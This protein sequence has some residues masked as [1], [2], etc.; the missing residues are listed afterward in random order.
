MSLYDHTKIEKKWQ[1]R[2]QKSNIYSSK[3]KSKKKK[4]YILDMFPYPSGDGLH[5]GHVKGYT[6]SDVL[7]R[8]KRMRGFNVLHPMGWDAFGLPAE[9]FAI[10]TRVH[11]KI[12]TERAIENFKKQIDS[13]GLSYDWGR[14][15]DTH[16]KEYYRWT[17]W[18][19]LLL[20][21]KGLAYRRRAPVNWDP[22]DQTVLANEQ[23][24]PDGTAER[25]GAK[26]EQRLLDQWFF[27]ITDYA[28]RLL[29]GLN[30][31][32][33]PESTKQ[34]QIN[35]I[36]KSEGAEIDFQ[37][38]GVSKKISVFTTRPDT[39]FGA[40]YLVL[41][42]EHP[43][44]EM[45]AQYVSNPKEVSDYVS[46]AK[47]KTELARKS[48]EKEK[49]GVELRGIKAI[50]PATKEKISVWVADYV[51][52]SYGS[53]AIMAV[54]AHDERDFQFAQK[55][56]LPV[57]QVVAPSF[58]QTDE[59]GSFKKGEPV[60]TK[61]GV[62]VLVKHWS[63]KKYIGLSWKKV[64]WGTLL[65]GGVDD[66]LSP[67]ETV[68]KEIKEETGY[69]SPKIVNKLGVVDGYFYHV[70]KKQNRLVHGHMY[71]VTL[72]DGTRAAV[73]TGEENIHDIKWL[74]LEELAG[75]LTAE[76]HKYTLKTFRE[77]YSPY[78]GSGSLVDSGQFTGRNNEEA[79]E[80]IVAFVGGR[81]KTIYK[82]RD[83]LISRQRYWG[84]PIRVV[85]DT[86]GVI[87][88]VSEKGLPIMLP[89]DVDF[90]PTGESPIKY[91]NEFQKGV[92][93]KY[94]AG[95]YRE[96][97]TMDTFVDSSWY[98]LRFTDPTNTKSFGDIEKIKYW[99]P[100]D[101]YIGGAEHTVLHLLYARFITKVLFD[102]GLV[103]FD[104]PFSALRH[105]GLISAADGRKMSKSYG[106]VINPNDLVRDVG[107]D[108]LRVFQMF[109]GPF[110]QGSA[111]D[112]KSVAG[113]RRFIER[114]WK[115]KE[116]IKSSG[117]VKNKKFDALLHFSIKKV[118]DDIEAMKFNTAISQMMILLNACEEE[119]EI[120]LSAY[121]IFLKLL[122][123]FAPHVTEELWRKIGEEKSIH[124]ERWPLYDPKKLTRQSVVL[125]VQINGKVRANIEVGQET[126]QKEVEEMAFSHPDVRK[127]IP[128]GRVKK[129]VYVPGKIIS[130]VV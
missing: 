50:N 69:Q 6:G 31:V 3:E 38:E 59:P 17:Q 28:D 87:T 37:I 86:K 78:A 84:A 74:T 104:E 98:F 90:K 4:Y 109:M 57:R 30:R 120:P 95:A 19:F 111:W 45:F 53:G 114:V 63:E 124:L 36:G 12:T 25:S 92:E 7:A 61:D 94:G 85:Y 64:A 112:M 121:K 35:W 54:P 71:A 14:E 13:L 108:S 33:W 9:N 127:W 34:G 44:V 20:Y 10:K 2:W 58:V 99:S 68:L 110:E 42:P 49:T 16:T 56:N 82:L 123:P 128:S 77:G 116:K 130:F 103:P 62:I 15:I 100:V 81:K 76:T 8:Y 122:S 106:N 26:V 52:I 24:L 48:A 29:E 97:D 43:L 23:V 73:A 22:V 72:E 67:E 1:T 39:V 47:K 129:T 55:F 102:E 91:S 107:A 101:L 115:L 27:K 46:V 79:K 11:P 88:A 125:P 126:S 21:K 70:P 5:V 18:L 65:T 83:W 60:V 75:F 118:G 89:E 119:V 117:I 96:A 105:Q 93:K 113:A 80:E 51:L 32:D 41:A 66:G 40:T